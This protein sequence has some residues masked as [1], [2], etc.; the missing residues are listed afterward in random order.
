MKSRDLIATAATALQANPLRS[1]LTTLGIVIGCGSVIAMA[2]IG[3]GAEARITEM[4]DRMGSNLIMVLPGSGISRGDDCASGVYD[5]AGVCDGDLVEDCAGECGG[6][7]VEDE[8]GV[9]NG[10]G[11]TCGDDG[12]AE[13][14]LDCE[15]VDPSWIEDELSTIE[16]IYEFCD[17]VMTLPFGSPEDMACLSDCIDEFYDDAF[18]VQAACDDCLQEQNCEDVDWDTDPIVDSGCDL[19]ENHLYLSSDGEVFYY[20]DTDIA[21]FQFDVDGASVNGADGGDAAAAGF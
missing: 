17:W 18:E 4:I 20:S 16:N 2:A 14:L 1:I 5:C 10:D 7:S 12:S 11:S 3:A 15:G 19:P 21:G 9:C 13:C 6:I 8:C